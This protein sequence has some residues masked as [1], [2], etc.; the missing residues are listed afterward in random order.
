MRS[1]DRDL[2]K[3]FSDC[4]NLKNNKIGHTPKESYKDGFIRRRC[5]RVQF[6]NVQFYHWLISIGITPAKSYTVG[7]IEIPPKYFRDFL[8]GHLDGDGT[9]FTYRDNATTYKGKTYDYL[10]VYTKFISVSEKHIKWLSQM[11]THY[12]PVQGS[13]ISR[14]AKGNRVVMW[15]IKIAK[16]ESL[17]LFRWLYYE[18][19]LP[20]LQR[21]RKLAERLL[22]RVR[23]NKLVR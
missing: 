5:Y 6:S 23:D 22:N 2:L 12:C 10:R 8:R 7:A 3:T 20:A 19:N 4:L 1:V 17:K 16:Y 15:E 14:P 11:M 9:I 18:K 13:L 21:K